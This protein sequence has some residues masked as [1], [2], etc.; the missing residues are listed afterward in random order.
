MEGEA[1]VKDD[2]EAPAETE[3]AEAVAETP[4]VAKNPAPRAGKSKKGEG[5]GSF[6]EN[7]YI[8]LA[9]DDSATAS[10]VYVPS[11]VL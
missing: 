4:Q 9:P 1:T 10:C 2:A 3:A 11:Y 6:K 8:F 7:P 5:G